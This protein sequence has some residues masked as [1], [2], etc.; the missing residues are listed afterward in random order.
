MKPIRTKLD[1][2][3]R[4]VIPT[5]FRQMLNLGTGDE[6][7]LH[8]QNDTIY[9]TTADQALQKLQKKVKNYLKLTNHDISLADELIA[10]RKKEMIYE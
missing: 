1:K 5:N 9:L 3:G 10:I 6:I 8:M 2:N 4:I 7:I